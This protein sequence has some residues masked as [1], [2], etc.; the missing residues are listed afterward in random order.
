MTVFLF[1]L[2]RLA[3]G[4]CCCRF[5]I[6]YRDRISALVL[7]AR[8]AGEMAVCCPGLNKVGLTEHFAFWTVRPLDTSPTGY[9]A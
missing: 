1:E 4:R 6:L 8:R 3:Q 7:K 2:R 9:F 5:I